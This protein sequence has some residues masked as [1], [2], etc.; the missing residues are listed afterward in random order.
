MAVTLVLAAQKYLPF[1]VELQRHDDWR[2][3]SGAEQISL[4][5]P[6]GS[7]DPNMPALIDEVEDKTILILGYGSIGKAIEARLAPFGAHF[8]RV[9]RSAA[10]GVT[11]PVSNTRTRSL[12]RT[13]IL[14]IITPLTSETHHLI[15]AHRLALMET[16]N[17]AGQRRPRS[18]RRHCRASP[19]TRRI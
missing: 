3:R 2:G 10:E 5:T 12:P 1:Y 6:G 16:W 17:A 15:A 19:R 8:I 18:Q 11:E 9:A 14:I 13:D 4:L 7:P